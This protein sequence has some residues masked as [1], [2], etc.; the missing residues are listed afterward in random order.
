MLNAYSIESLNNDPIQ[1][2]RE[3]ESK[4]TTPVPEVN[5]QYKESIPKVLVDISTGSFDSSRD[6]K[7]DSE[8]STYFDPKPNSSISAPD[9]DSDVDDPILMTTVTSLEIFLL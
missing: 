3:T 2:I 7:R 4:E 6:P 1:P 9:C 8:A 5:E